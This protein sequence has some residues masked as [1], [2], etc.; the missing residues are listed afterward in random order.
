MTAALVKQRHLSSQQPL[1]QDSEV[2]LSIKHH[3]VIIIE[4]RSVSKAERTGHQHC[5]LLKQTDMSRCS[6]VESCL[7]KLL[8]ITQSINRPLVMARTYF[9][10]SSGSLEQQMFAEL[11]IHQ[12]SRIIHNSLKCDLLI[13]NLLVR[14][15]TAVHEVGEPMHLAE[16][17]YPMYRSTCQNT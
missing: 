10:F 15:V 6:H 13:T 5:P 16:Q 4:L 17:A 12:R 14:Y 7:N 1:Q 3:M 2:T 9:S 11:Q 8:R